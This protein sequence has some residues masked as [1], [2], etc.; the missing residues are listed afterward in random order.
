MF[1][2]KYGPIALEAETHQ[3]ILFNARNP[4]GNAIETS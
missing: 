3:I 2:I 4:Y 1:Y